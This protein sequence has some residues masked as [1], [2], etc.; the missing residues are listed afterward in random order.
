[1]SKKAV[2]FTIFF[3]VLVIGFFVAL[4]YAVPGFVDQK[5]A[6]ISKVQPFA[7]INQ[8][9]GYTTE[10]DLE[11]KVA[12]VNF[13]FTTCRGICPKMSNNLK[14]VYSAF[15]DNPDFVL[16]S[17]TC[18]PQRDSASTLKRYA[19]SL[20]VDTKKWIFLTG[21]KDSLYNAARH[22]YKLDD[23]DNFVQKIEDDFLHT[24]YVALVNRKGE[25]IRIYDGI[26]PS[27]MEDMKND[28][29]EML[30]EK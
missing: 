19:D 7:F 12:A 27:E 25:V 13:F 18:D 29:A 14:P 2:F 9:G 20:G 10:K 30:K 5:I 28:I 4:S 3:T 11:G 15:K 17:H 6:P 16:L 21:R 8:D 23:P 22:S 1:M 24:Q 26:K